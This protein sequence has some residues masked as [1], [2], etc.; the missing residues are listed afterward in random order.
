MLGYD[1]L[2]SINFSFL[3]SVNKI[4]TEAGLPFFAYVFWY[5]LGAGV[6]LFAIAAIR[7]ELDDRSVE[8]SHGGILLGSS[9]PLPARLRCKLPGWDLIA[10]AVFGTIQACS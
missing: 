8:L 10:L 4:A 6:V 2:P 7:G 3:F 5:A 9:Y 1:P